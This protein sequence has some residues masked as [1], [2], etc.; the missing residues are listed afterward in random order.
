MKEIQELSRDNIVLLEKEYLKYFPQAIPA[1]FLNSYKSIIENKNLIK[2]SLPDNGTLN[3]LL[4]TIIFRI[5]TNQRFQKLTLLKLIRSQLVKEDLDD[6][7]VDKLFFLFKELYTKL[8]SDNLWIL[9]TLL[10]DVLLPDPNI[11]WLIENF[12]KSEHIQNRLLRYPD[13]NKTISNWASDCIDKHILSDRFSELIGLKLNFEPDYSH[14][15]STALLW[16]I[17]YSKLEDFK[18]KELLIRHLCD[19]NFTEFLTICEK[20]NFS[21]LIVD[22]YK[23]HF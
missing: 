23:C 3:I 16:G 6:A 4:D 5:S 21:D 19:D 9:S 2:Q 8:N 18:K 20:N 15:N 1:R 14:P 17:H 11:Y 22:L 10:K 7:I 13:T 12:E